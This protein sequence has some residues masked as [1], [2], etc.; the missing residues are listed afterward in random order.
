MGSVFSPYYAA[1][2]R[3]DPR[4]HVAI[5]AAIYTPRGRRW[6]MTERG[7]SSLRQA[8]DSFTV[9]PS[10][11]SWNSEGLTIHID[12]TCA[13]I[14]RPLR[15]VVRL[16]P[17]LLNG[18]SIPLDP[19]G[20][21]RWRPIAPQAD[22][23]AEFDD[24]R[25]HWR[26]VGYF[27]TNEGRESLEAGFAYWH[28]S[29]AHVGDETAILYEVERRDGSTEAHS[30]WFDR[31]GRLER[32]NPPKPIKLPNT[33]WGLRR[34]TRADTRDGARVLATWEDGPFYARSKIATQLYGQTAMAVHE[35]LDL[36]RFRAGWVHKLLPVRM[37]R[38]P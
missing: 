31:Q 15:G 12:E 16:R 26:G 28:W 29:R 17:S 24:P 37:P 21:H 14:Q 23:E 32:R 1:A 19:E 9:G 4:E 6:A 27:D 3:R 13:P 25:L 7:Q 18:E 2:G 11:L 8:R 38:R 20:R 34:D 10:R 36:N 22:V 33:I 5:N 30:L 35:A